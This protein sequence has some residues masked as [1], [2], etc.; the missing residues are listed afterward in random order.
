[1]AFYVHEEKG[2]VNLTV[3]NPKNKPVQK[4]LSKTRGY[5]EL[6]LKDSGIYTFKFLRVSLI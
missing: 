1:M 4:F 5:V 6:N 2:K 3:V